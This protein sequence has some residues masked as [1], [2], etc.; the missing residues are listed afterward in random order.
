MRLKKISLR[1]LLTLISIYIL[2]C[3]GM[4]FFQ[5][6]FIFHPQKLDN[7]FLF[8]FQ[9]KYIEKFFT[10]K[11]GVKLNAL[12][13][14]ADN[15]KGLIFYL[16]GNSGSLKTCANIAKTFTD[17][18]YDILML[19]YRG[20]GKSEGSLSSQ[21]QIFSDIQTVYNELKKDYSEKNI[22]VIGYSIG[23][24]IAAEMATH[25]NPKLLILQAPYYSL[26]DM[27]KREYSYLPTFLL[28]Y[29]FETNKFI[30]ECKMPVVI[31]HGTNDNVVPYESSLMLKK[32]FKKL[33]TLITLKNQ[34]HNNITQNIQY[35]NSIKSILASN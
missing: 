33:D 14:K 4:Y 25:N 31:F 15:P 13:F 23:T 29:K 17:I 2:I 32:H 27:M 21:E 18:N 3:G 30:T 28:K 35:L 16:H 6:K 24:G 10:T 12:H 20:F 7:N 19:D 11:D 8:Q 5:E 22:I 1:I 9:Q 26:I 34:D